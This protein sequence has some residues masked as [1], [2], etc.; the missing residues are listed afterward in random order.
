MPVA[1]DL[2]EDGHI[3]Y[4]K[5]SEPWTMEEVFAG[6]AETAAIR[7]KLYAED[8]LRH[9]HS[10][11]DL[12]EVNNPPPGALRSRQSPGFTHANRGKSVAAV[13]NSLAREL[14]SAIFRLTHVDGK[15][16]DTLDEAWAYLRAIIEHPEIE[17]TADA[18]PT[19]AEKPTID[20]PKK[21]I[22]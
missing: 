22:G 3:I 18:T 2:R 17:G 5:I 10:L 7:N 15:L 13:T 19:P 21:L 9:V 16:V 14:M 8:P 4:F 12:T 11:I 6:F 1:F 20:S